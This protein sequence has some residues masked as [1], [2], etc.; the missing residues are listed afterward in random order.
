[1]T[2]ILGAMARVI[3]DLSVY[4]PTDVARLVVSYVDVIEC[5]LVGYIGRTDVN[6]MFIRF[7]GNDLLKVIFNG[8]KCG[9]NYVSCLLSV[10]NGIFDPDCPYEQVLIDAMANAIA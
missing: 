3:R 2:R 8:K 4:F 10:L 6:P 9:I 1:M 5:F 7:P